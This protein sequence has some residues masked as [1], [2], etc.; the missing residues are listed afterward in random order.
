[1]KSLILTLLLSANTAFATQFYEINLDWSAEGLPKTHAQIITK[2]GE[3][4][5]VKRKINNEEFLLEVTPKPADKNGILMEFTISKINN[6]GEKTILSTP[7]ISALANE[8]AS[9]TL[10]NEQKAE[11]LSISALAKPSNGKP[12]YFKR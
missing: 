8:P 7:R 5:T 4:A 1:M 12:E 2:N 11:I 3:V 10:H 6:K 9:I